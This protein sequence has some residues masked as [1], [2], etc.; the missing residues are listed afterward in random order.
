MNVFVLDEDPVKAARILCNSHVCKMLIESAQLL[1]NAWPKNLSPYK[2]TH[3]GHPCSKW[4]RAS[5]YNYKW[6]LVHAMTICEEY[7]I[8]YGR[9][10]LTESRAIDKLLD[11]GMPD[12]PNI[13]LTPFVRAIKE[14]WR[15]QTIDLS[16]TEAYRIYYIG[17][18][19]HFA[20]WAPR[21]KPPEW[22]PYEE[23]R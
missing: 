8:R 21:A 7:T 19:S 11:M 13:G 18:K 9:K 4:T 6:L 1:S 16:I 17:D 14:P 22:W 20:K 3:F 23:R 15:T 2:H 10:H 5:L 12:L